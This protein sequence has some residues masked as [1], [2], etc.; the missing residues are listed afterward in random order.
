MSIGCDRA[1]PRFKELVDYV[2]RSSVDRAALHLK[3][4]A[5]HADVVRG[6]S[7]KTKLKQLE[8]VE[9]LVPLQWYLKHLDPD[10]KRP[11]REVKELVVWRAYQYYDLIVKRT[12]KGG[13]DLEN[14]LDL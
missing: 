10:G 6:E 1:L 9:L 4:K 7:Q 2:D 8:I 5:C 13:Y 14:A 11:F 12:T 3:I